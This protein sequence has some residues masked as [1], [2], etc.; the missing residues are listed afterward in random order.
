MVNITMQYASRIG[1]NDINGVVIEAV[2]AI[3]HNMM[4][5]VSL[6]EWFAW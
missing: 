5:A 6:L 4:L 3:G 2:G 1:K